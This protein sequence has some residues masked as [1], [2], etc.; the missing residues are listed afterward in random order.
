MKKITILAALIIMSCSQNKNIEDSSDNTNSIAIDSNSNFDGQMD[1]KTV[2][3]TTSDFLIIPGKSIGSTNLLDDT[4]SLEKFGEPFYSDAAMGKAWMAWTG[5]G[6]DALGNKATLAVYVTYSGSDM[7]KQVIKRIRVTSP[8]FK[9]SEGVNTGMTFI[10]IT[11][12][13]LN[14]ELDAKMTNSEFSK[15]SI[16][17][18]LKDAGISFEFQNINNSEICTAI[19]IAAID[20]ISNQPY[21]IL[22]SDEIQR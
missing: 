11:R 18:I 6:L 4:D 17:Y 14:L 10:E 9:T 5:S 1:S 22:D 12:I 15:E 2:S 16:F 21:L 7:S 3:A 8:D 13:Y 20:E 19:A